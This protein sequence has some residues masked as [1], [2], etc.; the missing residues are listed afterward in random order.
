MV[1]ESVYTVYISRIKGEYP[2]K[3]SQQAGSYKGLLTAQTLLLERLGITTVLSSEE[4][5]HE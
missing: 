4:S 3:Y 2:Y 1:R 5:D